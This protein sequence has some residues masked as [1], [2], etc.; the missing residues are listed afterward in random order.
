MIHDTSRRIPEYI[1][2]R[3]YPRAVTI[4]VSA[5]HYQPLTQISLMLSKKQLA[6]IFAITLLINGSSAAEAAEDH[7]FEKT[8]KLGTGN[9][10]PL[11]DFLHVADPTAVVHNGRVYVYGTNDQQ[12]L[13]SVGRDGKNSYAHIHSL[14]MMSS[15]DMVNWTYH[16]IIDVE[17]AAPW[18]GKKGVSWAPSIISRAES[19]GL[20]HF[21]MYY[22]HGGGGVGV[23]T[24]TSPVGPW[25]D[26]LGHD[27]IDVNTPGLT[28]CPAPFDPGAVIDENGVGWL[29]FGGGRSSKATT[30]LPGSARIVRLGSDLLSLDSEISE[31]PAPYFFEA[32]ELNYINGT[33][34]YSYSTDWVDRTEWNDPEVSHPSICSIGYMTSTDPLNRDSWK[35]RGDILKN[36]H[37]YGMEYTNNHTHFLRFNNE[38]YIFYH[39]NHLADFRGITTGYRNICVDRLEV[40]ENSIAIPTGQMTQTGVSQIKPLDPFAWQQAE[41]VA[42]TSGIKFEHTDVAGNMVACG[43]GSGQQSE[44]RGADFGKGAS[45]FEAKVR[46]KG[47]IDIHIGSSKGKRVGSLVIDHP[48]WQTV[49]VRLGKKLKGSQGLCFV[50][51]DGDF[52]F[53]EWRFI[54]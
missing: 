51:R 30:F 5:N 15:D 38:Y 29:S 48:Q 41:T 2:G 54:R 21:Y 7:Q 11:L 32:S 27:L 9:C 42:A 45:R 49:S 36:P 34:V 39:T 20:T 50:Y 28:D 16:G 47:V 8:P 23:I 24:A 17:Q 26:P 14:V 6:S 44:V 4:F 18:T 25:T 31:I 19:D 3:D 10:N 43:L 46:G 1:M 33:W 40:D 12:E 52:K 13:D 37:D 22:S 35:F 53:D